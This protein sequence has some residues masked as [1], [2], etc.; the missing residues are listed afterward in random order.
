MLEACTSKDMQANQES[1]IWIIQGYW[2]QNYSG[3]SKDFVRYELQYW[4]Q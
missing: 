4:I 2:W 3:R 1:S